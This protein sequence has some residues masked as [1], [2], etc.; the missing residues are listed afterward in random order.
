MSNIIAFGVGL[1]RTMRR[2]GEKK[3]QAAGTLGA[4]VLVAEGIFGLI[5]VFSPQDPIGAP[6]TPTG[7]IHIILARLSSL[8]TMLSML[9]MGFWFRNQPGL[10]NYGLYSFI[11]PAFVFLFGGLA[12]VTGA[13]R[14][15]ILGV[16]ER[17]VIG[18][19]LQWL[20]VIAYKLYS[21]SLAESIAIR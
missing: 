16:M 9:L 14:S 17:L 6:I 8:T 1:L 18:G 4:L 13:H 19:F 7:T 2:A 11:S 10:H 5:T 12:A 3:G 21:S 20:L 15:P